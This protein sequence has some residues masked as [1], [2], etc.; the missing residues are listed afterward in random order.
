MRRVAISRCSRRTIKEEP[1]AGISCESCHSAGQDWI[2]VHSGFSGK[3]SAVREQGRGEGALE[4]LRFQRNDQAARTL[5]AGEELLRLPRRAARGA[6][7]QRRPS[8]PA[9]PSS[10]CPGRRAR[11]GTTPGIRRART[12]YRPPRR[13]SACSISSASA[14]SSRPRCARSER[15][16][17][18]RAYAFEMAKR[19]DRARK[20]LADRGESGA[21]R[22]GNRKDG[23]ILPFGRPEAEQ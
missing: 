18:E 6:R 12:T 19:V 10:W 4:A 2:K 1:V 7:E 15:R 5:P 23:R 8:K 14:S 22:A 20:Q 3:T 17:R 21:E 16:P 13:A 9:A 11:C